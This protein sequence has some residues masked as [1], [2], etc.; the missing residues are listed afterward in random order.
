MG[1]I[2]VDNPDCVIDWFP[3]Y[4]ESEQA[5]KIIGD[6]PHPCRHRILKVVG[7]GP[8]LRHYELRICQDD[9][10]AGNCRGWCGPATYARICT[11][12]WKLLSPAA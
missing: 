6:C 4:P 5:R 10:C 1:S 3:D 11:I 7:W 2:A 8:S 12:D 9:G